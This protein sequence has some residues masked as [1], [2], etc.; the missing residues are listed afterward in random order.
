V[1]HSC[2]V[3]FRRVLYG[4]CHFGSVVVMLHIN[5]FSDMGK[6]IFPPFCNIIDALGGAVNHKV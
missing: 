1:K 2:S 6:Y 5:A 4:W 3:V